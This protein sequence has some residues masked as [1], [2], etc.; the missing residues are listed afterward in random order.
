MSKLTRRL[1]ASTAC[2]S[3][4]RPTS[5]VQPWQPPVQVDGATLCSASCSSSQQLR[6]GRVR[7][8]RNRRA[9]DVQG[10]RC[11]VQGL[12]RRARYRRLR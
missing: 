6:A 1:A 8:L 12:W 7:P 3:G 10:W 11:Q 4:G 2:S 5:A 9:G